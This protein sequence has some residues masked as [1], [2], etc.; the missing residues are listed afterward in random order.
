MNMVRNKDMSKQTSSVNL[1]GPLVVG[2]LMLAATVVTAATL[3][4]R[5]KGADCAEAVFANCEKTLKQLDS[6]VSTAA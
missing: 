3:K 1:V 4:R 6:R 5:W 2:G